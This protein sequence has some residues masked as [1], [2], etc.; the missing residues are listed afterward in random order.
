MSSSVA[1]TASVAP[2]L[3]Q[4]P[5]WQRLWLAIC[6]EKRR[7]RSMALLPAG[8]A[9]AEALVQIAVT[10]AHTGMV[11]MGSPIHVAD[12]TRVSLPQ[13]VPFSQGLASHMQEGELMM[14][15]L[16]GLTDN[17]TSLSLAK[18]ADCVLLCVMLGETTAADARKTV[19]QIGAGHF[20]GSAAFH[21]PDRG[22]HTSVYPA[23]RPHVEP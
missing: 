21:R 5:D 1:I 10:L 20:I 8:P 11:H 22:L 18:S 2:D 6:G 16:S 7:W 9:A 4:A 17:V 23:G 19:S 3:W 13:L 14:L 15:A 12:G